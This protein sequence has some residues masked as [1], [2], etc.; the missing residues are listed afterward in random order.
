MK[1]FIEV[2]SKPQI[3]FEI[4]ERAFEKTQHIGICEYFEKAR[5]TDIGA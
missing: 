2:V 3:G 1:N 4:K 5:N